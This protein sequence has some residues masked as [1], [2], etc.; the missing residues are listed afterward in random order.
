MLSGPVCAFLYALVDGDVL[1]VAALSIISIDLRTGLVKP[2]DPAFGSSGF[3]TPV[4]LVI[5]LGGV[6]NILLEDNMVNP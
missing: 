1:V 5:L 6:L 4:F 2:E 3:L